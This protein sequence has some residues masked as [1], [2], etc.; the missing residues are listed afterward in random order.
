MIQMIHNEDLVTYEV[1]IHP[2][3]TEFVCQANSRLHHITYERQ[4]IP[5]NYFQVINNAFKEGSLDIIYFYYLELLP[6]IEKLEMLEK[7]YEILEYYLQNSLL[8]YE[9]DRIPICN[10]VKVK[11]LSQAHRVLHEASETTKQ[12]NSLIAGK[13]LR[14]KRKVYLQHLNK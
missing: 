13:K 7:D 8:F 9:V 14:G 1:A 12:Y 10:F 4:N 3:K 11:V 2:E 5:V 6:H